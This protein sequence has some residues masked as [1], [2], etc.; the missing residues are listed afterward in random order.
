MSLDSEGFI[1]PIINDKCID[2]GACLRVCPI[3]KQNS[4]PERQK[5][6]IAL[7]KKIE[8]KKQAASGGVFGTI[9]QN[10]LTQPDT[11]VC[12][13]SFVDGCVKHIITQ[14]ISDLRKCQGSK[15]V[16]SYLTDVIPQIKKIIENEKNRV[17]FC[18]TPCQVDAIYAYLRKR[19]KNLYTLD[20]VCHGVPSPLFLKKDLMQY[21]KSKEALGNVKFRWRNPKFNKTHSVYFL[22]LEA[23]RKTTIYSSSY[24]PY[25]AT[26]MR[27]MS[28]RESCYQCHYANLKRVGD[29]TIGDCDSHLLYP[30]FHSADSKSTVI[31]N[32]EQGELLWNSI[33]DEFYFTEL[34]LEKE[35]KKNHQLSHSSPRP[36]ERDHIYKDLE[37]LSFSAFRKK[38]AS[39][40]SIQQKVL[41][42]IQTYLP[43]IYRIIVENT[44]R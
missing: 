37:N 16:Q 11:Y 19:P 32:T 4:M 22:S 34:D 9:A 43:T 5:S 13:A 44:V 33:E 26:F 15:Y 10:F 1:R 41:F 27:G 40:V 17:L 23:K 30:E 18:G 20:L 42:M 28:F 39:P 7:T 36:K 35:A 3:V 38:Y 14:N 25:F 8:I 21:E 6:F 12:A 2:C 24:D 29:I 31:L